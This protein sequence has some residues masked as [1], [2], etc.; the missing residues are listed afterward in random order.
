MKRVIPETDA[1]LISDYGKGLIIPQILST[2][3]NLSG[4]HNIPITVDPKTEH[5]LS[6]HKVTCITPNLQE[7]TSGMRFPKVE[8]EKE[9]ENLGTKI[10]NE[11]DCDSV[12]I[13]RGEKGMSIF[14][15]NKK[16]IRIPTR[17][18]E[19]FDVTGAGDTVVS[20]LSLCFASGAS[21]RMSAEI[22]NYAAGIVV[23]KLGT[24][25]VTGEELENAII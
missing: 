4:K 7:A 22:A 13:T 14:E 6:Y 15:K 21:L 17:A 1:V 3:I 8:S 5:F 18:K 9:I 12:I 11:L 16:P 23:G 25:T 24:A 19:V 20:V 2:A 10:L